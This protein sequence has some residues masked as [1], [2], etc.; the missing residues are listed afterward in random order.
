MKKKAVN[1]V[2]HGMEQR[3]HVN[4]VGLNSG[5]VAIEN[6]SLLKIWRTHKWIVQAKMGS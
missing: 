5:V 1:R 6:L 2:Q 4:Q 3:A